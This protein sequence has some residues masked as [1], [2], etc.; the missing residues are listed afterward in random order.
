MEDRD[1]EKEVKMLAEAAGMETEEMAAK[2]Q[3][4]GSDWDEE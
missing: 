4:A 1:I 3:T 2:I